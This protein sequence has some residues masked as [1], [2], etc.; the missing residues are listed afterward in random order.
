M[1]HY[2]ICYD[3]KDRRRLAKIHREISRHALFVQYSV[4][5][6]QGERETLDSV[7]GD[8]ENLMDPLED[9]LRVYCIR[10][11]ES[12]IRVGPSWLPEGI[13]LGGDV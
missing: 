3:I 9:D 7:I 13:W 6:F 2:L 5:Y 12:A 11:L 1:P 8:L 4:Y 10:S